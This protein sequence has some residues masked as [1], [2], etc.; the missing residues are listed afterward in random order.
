[1]GLRAPRVNGTA[2]GN[3]V[4][5]DLEVTGN[6]TISDKLI[7]LAS[8]ITGTPSGDAGIIVERGSSTNAA[9]IWDESRDE[10]VLG[11]TSAT[12]AS[13][14]DLTVT[15]GNLSVERI[16]AGTEQA[17][18]EVHAK[19]DTASGVQYSTTATIISEDDT[20]PSIQIAG[21]ASNIGLIQFG[22]NAAVAAGQIYYDH[23]TDKLRVDC[24]ENGDRLTLDANGDMTVV[25]NVTLG[26]GV[27]QDTMLAFD[28][29]AVDFRIGLDDG[30]DS[31]EIG[32]G[33]AH[34]TTTALTISTLGFVK[35]ASLDSAPADTTYSGITAN[36]VA[37]EDL[38]D[39]EV[40]YLKTSDGKLW[41][42]V[43]T[44]AATSR[45]IAM[46]TADVSADAEGT[47]LLQGFAHF[48]TN[49]PTYT[50]GAVVYTPEAEAGGK[51]VPEE[52][53]PDTD[54]DFVQILGYA[55]TANI[56]YFA[57]DS[58]VIEVA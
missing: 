14:G 35:D 19:R 44:A 10:F 54:G 40:V 52:A 48:A 34:G 18:A 47:F 32:A 28:G 58:T 53:A 41:K 38:E 36:F 33:T 17:E 26:G 43:A 15:P 37:G 3:V 8:G 23:S 13:T 55:A 9:I 11:T 49:F 7:E 42:A 21:G 2:S 1:M 24:G 27:E 29:N 16:G 22:D 45:A 25:R 46:C 39:G 6:T 31:L 51:N 57:P 56:L 5:T 4:L 20:R 50:V 30:T 12:G